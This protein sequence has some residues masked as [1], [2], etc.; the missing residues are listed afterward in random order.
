[1]K[2]TVTLVID[3]SGSMEDI[4]KDSQKGIND[5]L[6]ANPQSK[7]NIVEFGTYTK[8]KAKDWNLTRKGDQPEF[9]VS[10][11]CEGKMGLDVGDY[12]LNP[13][14]GTP[15]YDGIGAG[16]K[17]L[18]LD[19]DNLVA[20]ITDGEENNSS[21]WKKDQINLLITSMTKAGAEFKFIGVGQDAYKSSRGLGIMSYN[22]ASYDM[23]DA[24]VAFDSIAKSI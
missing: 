19:E 1:M 8:K 13:Q 12:V 9:G 20:I 16:L 23:A 4:K 3:V 7:F 6:K 2:K 10:I 24:D 5:I 22:I 17:L 14:G 15:L 21:L 18:D 11:A